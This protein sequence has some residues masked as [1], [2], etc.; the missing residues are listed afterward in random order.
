MA[1]VFQLMVKSMCEHV[2]GLSQLISL[3]SASHILNMYLFKPQINLLE[4]R[5][6]TARAQVGRTVSKVSKAFSHMT[7]KPR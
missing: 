5:L 4:P 1:G 2:L 6:V 7:D 3:N